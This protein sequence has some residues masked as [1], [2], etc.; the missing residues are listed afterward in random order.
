[1]AWGSP[2][3]PTSPHLPATWRPF[4]CPHWPSGHV[5][6]VTWGSPRPRPCRRQPRQPCLTC[7]TSL[8]VHSV[9]SPLPLKPPGWHFC[10]GCFPPPP[11]RQRRASSP[12]VAPLCPAPRDGGGTPLP[13][14][15]PQH[16]LPP[17]QWDRGRSCQHPRRPHAA[18]QAPSGHLGWV[19]PL[20][21]RGAGGPRWVLMAHAG[22]GDPRWV[23]M[24]HA[25]ARD[26]CWV[27]VVHARCRWPMPGASGACWVPVA[28]AGCW[29]GGVLHGLMVEA[30]EQWVPAGSGAAF[31]PILPTWPQPQEEP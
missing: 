21:G 16:P 12:R 13:A 1:M 10:F 9:P 24:A 20:P 31:N 4:Q 25:G 23:P 26:P 17:S 3:D 22:A 6:G 8:H 14:I 27:L 19:P 11:A 2:W 30:G 7:P 5:V 29:C 28:H 15:S 18:L